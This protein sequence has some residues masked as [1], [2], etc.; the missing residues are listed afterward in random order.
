MALKKYM[1]NLK[2]NRIKW[3]V[4]WLVQQITYWKFKQTKKK[5]GQMMTKR[6]MKIP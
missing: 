6:E 4:K 5:F 1:L 3:E 2:S